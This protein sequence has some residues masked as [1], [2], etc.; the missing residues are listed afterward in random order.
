MVLAVVCAHIEV[1]GPVRALYGGAHGGAT[2]EA[3][4]CDQASSIFP[5]SP[6]YSDFQISTKTQASQDTISFARAKAANN[7]R[8]LTSHAKKI[9]VLGS[10]L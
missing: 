8:S 6:H 4:A 7:K 5:N 9:H 10:A 3:M 1:P 2:A